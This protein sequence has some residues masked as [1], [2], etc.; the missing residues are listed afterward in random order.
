MIK[1]WILRFRT[2]KSRRQH[3]KLIEDINRGKALLE[4]IDNHLQKNYYTRKQRKKFWEEFYK[5]NQM[6]KHIY[7]VIRKAFEEDKK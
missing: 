5:S 4:M 7:E 3:A 6:R 1:E 2:R